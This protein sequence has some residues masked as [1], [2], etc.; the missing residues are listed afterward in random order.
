MQLKLLLLDRAIFIIIIIIY[1][2]GSGIIDYAVIFLSI[3]YS[4]IIFIHFL[5]E[6]P[7]KLA[8]AATKHQPWR[9]LNLDRRG[10]GA[11]D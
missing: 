5:V 7:T 11:L 1:L 4:P 10:N 6:D 2:Y 8:L 9:N 3:P